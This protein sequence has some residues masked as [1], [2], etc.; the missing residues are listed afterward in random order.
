MTSSVV[1]GD[2]IPQQD[3]VIRQ[4]H[5]QNKAEFSTGLSQALF[6]GGGIDATDKIWNWRRVYLL[7]VSSRCSG[8]TSC[9]TVQLTSIEF[10]ASTSGS[11][12][13]ISTHQQARFKKVSPRLTTDGSSTY[14]WGGGGNMAANQASG[15]PESLLLCD[16]STQKSY[17]LACM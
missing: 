14:I 4:N 6:L 9:R 13:S 11:V 15:G 10:P 16:R 17:I 3:L 7:P 5:C 1:T 8:V 2:C 12:G